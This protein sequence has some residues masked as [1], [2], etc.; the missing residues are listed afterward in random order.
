LCSQIP[1]FLQAPWCAPNEENTRKV[2]PPNDVDEH[3]ST[4]EHC[5]LDGHGRLPD[6]EGTGVTG[7]RMQPDDTVTDPL[8]RAAA[9]HQVALYVGQ[10]RIPAEIVPDIDGIPWVQMPVGS[11]YSAVSMPGPLA[12]RVLLR[13]THAAAID[14]PLQRRATVLMHPDVRP[15]TTTTG[16]LQRA[17]ITIPTDGSRIH[18]PVEHS[19]CPWQWIRP[20]TQPARLAPLSQ[21]LSALT[22]SGILTRR[23]EAR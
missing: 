5:G 23:S 22:A 10:Y 1:A 16:M 7:H 19:D 4:A 6:I 21:I 2:E 20:P 17:G 9:E 18:L 3:H 14:Y 13:L 12:G 11:R 15:D 8:S